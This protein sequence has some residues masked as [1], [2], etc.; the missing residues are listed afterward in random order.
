MYYE[1]KRT[2]HTKATRRGKMEENIGFIVVI[3]VVV[4]Y[5]ICN[6]LCCNSYASNSHFG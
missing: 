2:T 6:F 5:I 3:V 1:Q 4:S